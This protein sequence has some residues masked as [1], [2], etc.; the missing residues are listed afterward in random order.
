MA[1]HTENDKLPQG[2]APDKQRG[3]P[4]GGTLSQDQ[5]TATSTRTS[6]TF[7]LGGAR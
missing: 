2:R 7:R 4:G 3:C 1:Q 5:C 6:I